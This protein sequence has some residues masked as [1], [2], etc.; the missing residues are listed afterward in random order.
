[1]PPRHRTKPEPEWK[2]KERLVG[3]LEKQIAPDATVT[4]NEFL[5]EPLTGTRRQCDVVIRR[6]G[7]LRESVTIVEV[8]KRKKEVSLPTYQGWI[9]KF[10]MLQ[11]QH[12]ICVS[13]KGFSSNVVSDAATRGNIVRLLTLAELSEPWPVKFVNDSM[14]CHVMHADVKSLNFET[15]PPLTETLDTFPSDEPFLFFSDGGSLSSN[16]YTNMV[17]ARIIASGI[18]IPEEFETDE[19]V[20]YPPGARPYVV[21]KGRKIQVRS[22]HWKVHYKVDRFEL[23]LVA[24]KYE[25]LLHNG[26]VAFAM[27][28]RTTF[29]GKEVKGALIFM[30]TPEGLLRFVT[31]SVEGVSGI[32]PGFVTFH[33]VGSRTT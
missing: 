8:Q 18:A 22:A 20:P 19:R 1:M 5:T 12:L 16:D 33:E 23:P 25:Q 4:H 9:T 29:E 28:G 3:L 15:E 13:E 30:P 32:H 31:H 24:S 21:F 26:V 14:E 17:S 10:Q 6:G 2:Y 7:P 27:T 11:A